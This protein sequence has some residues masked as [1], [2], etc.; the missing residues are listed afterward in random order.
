MPRT[1]NDADY[2]EPTQYSSQKGI[3][4]KPPA[5][6]P[7]PSFEPLTIDANEHPDGVPTIPEGI[8]EHPIQLF[9]LFFTDQLLDELAVYTNQAAERYYSSE[10]G[11]QSQHVRGW[12]ETSRQELYAYFGVVIY[13]GIH[14]EPAITDYWKYTTRRRFRHIVGDYI[15]QVRFQQ[16]NRFIYCT[17]PD[18]SFESPFGR[19]IH[20]SDYIQASS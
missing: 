4:T 10:N 18:Q 1:S 17:S 12:R 7:P 3:R 16:I 6:V 9:Q 14:K 20:I 13:M 19:I 2:V 11:P 8:D 5:T 15:G